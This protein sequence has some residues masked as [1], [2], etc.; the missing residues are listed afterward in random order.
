MTVAGL[1]RDAASVAQIATSATLRRRV[2]PPVGLAKCV[3]R[4]LAFTVALSA[5]SGG[6]TGLGGMHVATR[7]EERAGAGPVLLKLLTVG[8]PV[9]LTTS[10][11]EG[12]PRALK[13]ATGSR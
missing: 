4:R 3:R 5:R 6:A 2:R 7:M 11:C 13:T 9:W 8:M 12:H 1:D 10:Q